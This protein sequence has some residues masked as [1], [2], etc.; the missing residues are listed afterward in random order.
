MPDVELP[1]HEFRNHLTIILGYSELLLKSLPP[2]D[3]RRVDLEEIRDAAG[4]A[5]DLLSKIFPRDSD[6]QS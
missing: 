2:D 1:R 6:A 4:A 3:P 5:L